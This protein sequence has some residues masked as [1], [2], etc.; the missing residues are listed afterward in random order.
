MSHADRSRATAIEEFPLRY[1][2]TSRLSAGAPRTFVLPATGNSVLFCRS[3]GPDDNTLALW[4]LDIATGSERLLL[5]PAALGTGDDADLPPAERARRERAREAGSG[6][7]AY[8]IDEKATVACCAIGGSL[9]LVDLTTGEVTSPALE[10]TV[11]DPRLSPNGSA[12]AYVDGRALR[13]IETATGTPIASRLDDDPLVSHGRAEFVAAEEMQRPRGFWWAPDSSALLVARVD[14]N[15]VTEWWIADPAHPG[16]TPNAVRYPAAGTANATVGLELVGLDGTRSEIDWGADDFEYLADVTWSSGHTPLAVRQRRDQRLVSIAELDLGGDAPTELQR[17]T[18]DVWVELIPGTPAWCDDHL[19]TIEDRHGTRRLCLDGDPLTDDTIQIR[20]LIGIVT[21]DDD[22]PSPPPEST[23]LQA[24]AVATAWVSPTEI[25]VVAI[26]L[27]DPAHPWLSLSPDAGVAAGQ[28]GPSHLLLSC[29]SPDTPGTTTTVHRIDYSL[30]QAAVNDGATEPLTSPLLA[31]ADHRETAGFAAEPTF[32]VLG[33]RELQSAVFLPTGHDGSTPLPVILD[34]YGGPHAQRVL[35]THDAHLVSRWLA[36][37][38]YAVIVT[39]G[40]G[41]PGRGPD[42]ERMVYGNLADPVLD[43]QVAA[44]ESAGERYPLD[45]GRVGIRGWSFGG[46]LAALAVLRR[47][48]VFHAAI[49]G[50]PVTTWH[51]YDTHYTERYLG[52]PT[53]DPDHYRVSDLFVPGEPL[54]LDRPLLLVHGLADDNVVAAHTLRFSTELL[55]SGNP[56]QV[57]PL[58][59]VTHMTPQVAVAANLLRLQLDFFD[60]HLRPDVGGVTA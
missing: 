37:H 18:D 35:R 47:P 51:L 24:A 12:V 55:A 17:I 31:I 40:R 3:N 2:T 13:V 59:G 34:P 20:S 5:D 7:V 11:F 26:C 39:D 10:G 19:L 33:A 21:A 53:D 29:A 23:G 41:T 1:A 32:T 22:A 14:E 46:Y 45:R 44:L 27:T 4:S 36:E 28:L 52:H 48:D 25:Q 30:L 57:L 49:A 60:T 43:D 15:P 56:H 50:A 38:G 8:T 9:F 42:W 16:R 58:S 6:V 54:A